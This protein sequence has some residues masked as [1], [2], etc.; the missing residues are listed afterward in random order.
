[1]HIKSLHFLFLFFFIMRRLKYISLLEQT[2]MH[3]CDVL[4]YPQ[5][6]LLYNFTERFATAAA[7]AAFPCIFH[8]NFFIFSA[9]ASSS[10]T[11]TEGARDV[12]ADSD[13]AVAG[14]GEGG[15]GLV[16]SLERT[17]KQKTTGVL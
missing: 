4:C 11:I 15:G 9:D 13:G 12:T 8:F 2:N 3:F 14:K 1:M 16:T 10:H 5:S 6:L 7:A 17:A